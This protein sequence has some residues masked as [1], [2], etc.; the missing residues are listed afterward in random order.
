MKQDIDRGLDPLAVQARTE[1]EQL[2]DR[3]LADP[4]KQEALEW[5]GGGVTGE[6]RTVGGCETNHD[7]IEFIR[8]IY[9]LGASEIIAVNVHRHRKSAGER[10]GKLVV[11]LPQDQK[12][13]IAI[14]DWCKRQ[15]D[16]LGFT[17]DLDQGESHLFLLLD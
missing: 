13:R 2:I 16:S 6:S 17:P 14:F 3:L 15:G 9:N 5:L 11:T 4:T 12:Q 7:S 8:E 10:T 1:H